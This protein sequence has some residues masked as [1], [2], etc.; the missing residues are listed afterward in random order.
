MDDHYHKLDEMLLDTSK[1]GLWA[2]NMRTEEEKYL[3]DAKESCWKRAREV[4]SNCTE[5]KFFPVK[6]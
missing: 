6:I 1:N 4:A 5:M 3:K 2:E